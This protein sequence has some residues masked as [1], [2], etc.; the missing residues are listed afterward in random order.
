MFW[1]YLYEM[2]RSRHTK[3]NSNYPG[4][5]VGFSGGSDGK[6]STGSARDPGWILRSGRSGEGKLLQYSCLENH[7]DWG[8]WRAT[9]HRDAESDTTEGLTNFRAGGRHGIKG[10]RANLLNT[11]LPLG[12]SWY[13]QRP[14]PQA[15]A[16]YKDSWSPPWLSSGWDFTF[17]CRGCRFNSWLGS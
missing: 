13:P 5:G 2:S 3:Q 1:F 8:A 17:Q 14:W 10:Q 16:N 7:V 11:H 15:F 12:G 6:E 4:L 9:V